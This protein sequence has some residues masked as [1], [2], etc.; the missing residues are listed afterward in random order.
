MDSSIKEKLQEIAYNVITKLNADCNKK[1]LG[2]LLKHYN[3]S[4]VFIDPKI[5]TFYRDRTL[6]FADYAYEYYLK[7]DDK[8]FTF[9]DFKRRTTIYRFNVILSEEYFEIGICDVSDIS[10]DIKYLIIYLYYI[11]GKI[12]LPNI[13]EISKDSIL[14]NTNIDDKI[15][16]KY[17]LDY[18][19]T[20][21]FNGYLFKSAD[22]E[23]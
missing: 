4:A 5:N 1:E 22:C 21:L 15:F 10:E 20:G 7:T 13:E 11:Q 9:K 14:G 17:N 2:T 8:L 6:T 12:V 23:G 16:T 3:I 19:K 18:N